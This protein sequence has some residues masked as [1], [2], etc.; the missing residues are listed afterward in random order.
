VARPE[1]LGDNRGRRSRF[2][3]CRHRCRPGARV[4]LSLRRH[5][6]FLHDSGNACRRRS[7]RRRA[8]VRNAL[9]AIDPTQ[10]FYNIKTLEEVLS[11]SI[12]PRRFNL[13]L[14]GTFAVVA[15]VLAALAVYGVVAYA[16][17]ERTH[18][19]GI[20]M[21]LG[22]ERSNVVRMMLAQGM[23]SVVAG[24]VVGL[25]G[26]W[27]ATQLIAGLLYDVQPHDAA[28]FALTTLALASIACLACVVPAFKAALVDPAAALRA[29]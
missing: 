20:R 2:E 12:A 27:A 29:E 15:L 18:E 7:D 16:V 13:L 28:T 11:D 6:G 24:L 25:G 26:A 19:I 1:W 22:A 14:L 4:V 8:R 10:S 3:V 21:A 5:A 9:S 23:W 17:A